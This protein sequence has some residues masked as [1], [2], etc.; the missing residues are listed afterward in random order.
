MLEGNENSLFL[1]QKERFL[2]QKPCIIK[3]AG[4]KF[5]LIKQLLTV[6]SL[7]LTLFRK[8]LESTHT[9]IKI[10][11][12]EFSH[13]FQEG[14]KLKFCAFFG[15]FI[16]LLIKDSAQA[17]P[18]HIILL[19][20]NYSTQT[21]QAIHSTLRYSHVRKTL[22]QRI[23]KELQ[24]FVS[25]LKRNLILDVSE[26]VYLPL[27]SGLAMNLNPQ[28]LKSLQSHPAV[29]K[30]IPNGQMEHDIASNAVPVSSMKGADQ[31]LNNE[32][33]VLHKV[34][35]LIESG[36][37]IHR[38]GKVVGIIDTGIDG[39]HPDLASKLVMFKNFE[40]NSTTPSD[41]NGHGTHVAGI[42]AGGNSSGV[43]IGVYPGAKLVVARAL[44][45]HAQMVLALQWM[46]DPDNDP[47]TQDQPYVINNSWNIGSTDT[48]PFYLAMQALKDADILFCFSAGNVGEAG[49]TR[50]KEFPPTFTT[51]NVD[52]KGVI[53][54]SSSWGPSTYKNE[55]QLKPEVAS[56]G[57]DVFSTL[58]DGRYGRMSGTSMASPFTAG[59][60]ALLGTYFP[61]L[62][63]YV[64]AE[65]L[66]RS[67][68]RVGKGTWD[69][70]YGYGLINVHSAYQILK[71]EFGDGML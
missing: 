35:Q 31:G 37:D 27:I 50:P 40:T 30:V 11:K 42:I 69:K 59:S 38:P 10:K 56:M 25:E 29:S 51:A 8:T 45:S 3:Y 39:T 9:F 6:N 46:L 22:D 60:I 16:S 58:P 21:S 61:H 48:A 44:R 28:Q 13:K 15:V 43:Q 47:Q 66:V 14:V 23:L 36:L 53:A 32:A 33:L 49:L 62:S 68:E 65:V 34:D 52:N 24:P 57:T 20:T 55:I 18:T 67:S 63:P 54:S 64:V 70:Q 17:D 7:A 19:K 26:I 41:N 12:C 5:D 4:L 2:F 1:L 71:Q